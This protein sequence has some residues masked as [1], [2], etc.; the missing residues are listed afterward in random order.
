M[1]T[2]VGHPPPLLSVSLG[3]GQRRAKKRGSN[4]SRKQLKKAVRRS[5]TSALA[6]SSRKSK[7]ARLIKGSLAAKR[8]M[9]GLR[10]LAMKARKK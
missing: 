3:G 6:R 5:A 7:P 8:H 2:Y 10:K 4:S 1:S 9:A